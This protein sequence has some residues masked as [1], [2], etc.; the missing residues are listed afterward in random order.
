MIGSV[1]LSFCYFLVL[2]LY[3]V[4]LVGCIMLCPRASIFQVMGS[5]KII[6]VLAAAGTA[7]LNL[8]SFVP[9]QV[10]DRAPLTRSHS[11][12]C[13]CYIPWSCDSLCYRTYFY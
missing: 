4:G 5:P 10:R 12:Q 6:R 9:I 7:L 8:S 3:K 2:V 13:V 1:Y 11:M